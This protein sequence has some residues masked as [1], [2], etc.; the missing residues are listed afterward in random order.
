MDRGF[1]GVSVVAVLLVVVGLAVLHENTVVRRGKLSG[2]SRSQPFL[3]RDFVTLYSGGGVF[4]FTHKGSSEIRR[5][6]SAVA[7]IPVLSGFLAT[8]SGASIH[9]PSPGNWDWLFLFL[10]LTGAVHLLLLPY[11]W[12]AAEADMAIL[13]EGGTKGQAYFS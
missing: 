11:L 5:T 7:F 10:A 12:R 2:A 4:V 6:A 13:K 1:F 9:F 3:N 8:I